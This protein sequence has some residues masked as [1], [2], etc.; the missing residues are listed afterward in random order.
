MNFMPLVGFYWKHGTQINEMLAKSSTPG[1][2][3]L[4]L[5]TVTAMAPVIKKRWPQ[6]NAN[7]LI[8]DAVQTLK[9]VLTPTPTG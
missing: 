1:Q 7:N 6:L 5:D 3:S 8:D 9:E 2:S 4:A